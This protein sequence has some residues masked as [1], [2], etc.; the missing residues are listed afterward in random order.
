MPKT[1]PYC[2]RQLKVLT[3]KKTYI[4]MPYTLLSPISQ[5]ITNTLLPQIKLL[6]ISIPVG[7]KV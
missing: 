6:D 1:L 3:T 4:F 5:I 2:Q 7:L